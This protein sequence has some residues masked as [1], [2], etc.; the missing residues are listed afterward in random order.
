MNGF[1]Y[2]NIYLDTKIVKIDY[3]KGKVIEEYDGSGLV[4]AEKADKNNRLKS[5]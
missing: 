4:R 2:A 5:D 3:E 1:I